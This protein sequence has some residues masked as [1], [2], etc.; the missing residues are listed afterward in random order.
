M[1]DLAFED[2]EGFYYVIDVKTHRINSDF[3][4]PALTSVQRLSKLYEDDMN[5]F[6]IIMVDYVVDSSIIIKNVSYYPIEFFDWSCLTI[7]ALGWGQIQ[8]KDSSKV[9]INDLFSRKL[10]MI[11]LCDVMRE[12]YPKEIHKITSRIDFFDEIRRY[13]INK[14]DIWA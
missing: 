10:W 5:V 9:K 13:W 4:M 8:I 1:A 14:E 6:S 7:G 11:S 12:F 3:N 2:K